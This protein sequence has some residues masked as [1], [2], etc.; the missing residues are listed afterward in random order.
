MRRAKA[1]RPTTYFDK[2]RVNAKN[3]S[4]WLI[5]CQE[6]EAQAKACLEDLR[7]YEKKLSAGGDSAKAVFQPTLKVLTDKITPLEV[8]LADTDELLIKNIDK[9]RR[10]VPD[11]SHREVQELEDDQG[12]QENGRR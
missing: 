6:L 3:V 8:I 7:A 11:C 4:T 9:V 1:C 10:R 12:P 2:S 5:T